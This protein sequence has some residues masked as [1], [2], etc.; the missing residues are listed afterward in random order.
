MK[1]VFIRIYTQ[2]GKE[3]ICRVEAFALATDDYSEEGLDPVYT[4]KLYDISKDHVD[5]IKDIIKGGQP[6]SIHILHED[7]GIECE[8]I[9]EGVQILNK[10]NEIQYETSTLTYRESKT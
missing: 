1:S 3:H 9:L 5:C 7:Q 8:C 6:C 4:L 10:L 2:F